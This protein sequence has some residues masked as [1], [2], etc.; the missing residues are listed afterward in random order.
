MEKNSDLGCFHTLSQEVPL[1]PLDQCKC[2]ASPLQSSHCKLIIAKGSFH[3]ATRIKV[4]SLGKQRSGN[5]PRNIDIGTGWWAT[6][7][8]VNHENH[9]YFNLK[10]DENYNGQHS[11]FIHHLNVII[12]LFFNCIYNLKIYRH[13]FLFLLFSLAQMK[14]LEIIKEWRNEAFNYFLISSGLWLKVHLG[15][16]PTYFPAPG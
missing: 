7:E 16:N 1:W 10:E 14:L 9:L 12:T 13:D 4:K 8:W 11:R 5:F 3:L 2:Q 6:E 15:H